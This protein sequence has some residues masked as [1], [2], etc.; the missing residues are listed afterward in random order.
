MQAG[1]YPL[2][3]YLSARVS[4]GQVGGVG[5]DAVGHQSLL[6]VVLVGQAQVLLQGNE[7]WQCGRWYIGV[8]QLTTPLSKP[9]QRK[10]HQ[11]YS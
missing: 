7:K 6:H 10:V 9:R 11:K 5:G 3:E 1:L 2:S 4:F 8:L